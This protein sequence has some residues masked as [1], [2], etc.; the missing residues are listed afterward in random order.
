MFKSL[1]CALE[2]LEGASVNKHAAVCVLG[3]A[4][5]SLIDSV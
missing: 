1:S 4:I 5:T 3:N 2:T